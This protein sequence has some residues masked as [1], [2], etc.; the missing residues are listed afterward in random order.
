MSTN[1]EIITDALRLLKVLAEGE[2]PSAEQASDALR[3][4]N[5]MLATWE[6]DGV[7]LGYFAQSD[8]TTTCPVPDWAEKGV[9]GML[10]IELA[11]EY[12]AQIS[13]EAAKVADD[14]YSLILR[15]VMTL[16]MKGADMS[17]LGAGVWRF[18]ILTDV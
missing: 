3:R 6:V 15:R 18:N 4:M 14:G 1:T 7:V 8:S 13:Q 12:G 5:Q 11:P 9:M 16:A 2:T 10:A 17:H